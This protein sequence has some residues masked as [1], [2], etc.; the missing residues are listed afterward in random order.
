MRAKNLFDGTSAL[1]TQN[2]TMSHVSQVSLQNNRGLACKNSLA[3]S[4]TP[5]EMLSSFQGFA[6]TKSRKDAIKLS[7]CSI[8]TSVLLFL[9]IL[10]S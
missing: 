7:L 10:F 9:F 3:N 6:L 1:K 5:S 4:L 2:I 8:T